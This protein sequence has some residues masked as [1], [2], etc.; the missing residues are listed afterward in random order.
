MC[1]VRFLIPPPCG[2]GRPEAGVG[3]V[4]TVITVDIGIR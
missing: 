1:E 4:H 3:G 2:E